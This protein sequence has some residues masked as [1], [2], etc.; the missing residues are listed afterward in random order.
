MRPRRG[1]RWLNPLGARYLA[2]FTVVGVL[3]AV[4]GT[5]WIPA[6]STIPGTLLWAA[7]LAASVLVASPPPRLT[8]LLTAWILS[9]VLM[10]AATT[11]L[12]AT[13][14]TWRG[15]QVEA[16][17]VALRDGA[18]K[19]LHLYY[20]LDG[21]DGRRVPGELGRWPGS[22]LGALDNPEGAVGQRVTVVRDAEGL[23]DPRLPEE[24]SDARSEWIIVGSCSWLVT[25]VLCM[26]AGRPGAG[27][28]RPSG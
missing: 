5:T 4:C 22:E 2:V 13:V 3:G 1:L 18:E 11:G 23:V 27:R 9:G 10:A 15:E 20:T 12:W 28:L 6:D 19:G 7:G 16:T 26:L 8:W 14:L 17:V 25:A 21:P 24:L